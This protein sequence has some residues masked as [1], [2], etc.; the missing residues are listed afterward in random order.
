MQYTTRAEME[1]CKWN[2]PMYRNT[3]HDKNM[4]VR[5]NILLHDKLDY[6]LRRNQ[7][8]STGRTSNNLVHLTGTKKTT[9]EASTVSR[10]SELMYNYE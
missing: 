8:L 3:K 7:M 6:N 1:S 9:Q 5:T 4:Q 2:K 10:F